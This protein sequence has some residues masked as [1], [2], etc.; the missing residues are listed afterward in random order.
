MEK[1]SLIF[2]LDLFKTQLQDSLTMIG[3]AILNE[4]S[5]KLEILDDQ[6]KMEAIKELMINPF[7]EIDKVCKALNIE[8]QS[9]KETPEV[10]E[11]M[12]LLLEEIKTN[13]NLI[14]DL[15]SMTPDEVSETLQKIKNKNN[16]D[17][18]LQ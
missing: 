14:D 8:Y 5:D 9:F 7:D 13:P 4:L 18:N 10:K 12:V 16:K 3:K 11:H 17:E 2:V 1:D 6:Q 15:L